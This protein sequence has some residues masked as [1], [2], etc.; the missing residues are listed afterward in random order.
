MGEPKRMTANE[1]KGYIDLLGIISKMAFL[2]DDLGKRISAV[3]RGNFRY[4]GHCRISCGCQTIFCALRLRSS[5]STSAGSCR[6][7]G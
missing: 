3:D 5:R 6:Q 4:K 7:S 2:E 1:Q